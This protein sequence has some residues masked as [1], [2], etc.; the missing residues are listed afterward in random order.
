MFRTLL[1]TLPSMSG[2]VKLNCNLDLDH[3]YNNKIIYAKIGK[4]FLT[5]ADH[6]KSSYVHNVNLLNSRWDYDVSKF[7]SFYSKVFF[8]SQFVFDKRD[9][10]KLN[11]YDTIKQRD[12]DFE[13]GVSRI[14]Y[15]VYGKQLSFFAPIYVDNILDLPNQFEIELKY[16]YN[17]KEIVKKIIVPI[18]PENYT[19]LYD[20]DNQFYNYLYRYIK[21]IDSKI[22]FLNNRK[23]KYYGINLLKGGLSEAE[24]CLI[25]SQLNTRFYPIQKVDSLITSGFQQLKMC[26]KQILPL[27]F[28]FDLNDLLSS[29]EAGKI[30]L[31]KLSIYG[32]YKYTD[33]DRHELKNVTLPVYDFFIDPDKLYID[34]LS[35]DRTNLKLK[36]VKGKN[37]NLL[38]ADAPGLHESQ[39][40]K[41]QFSNRVSPNYTKWR[42]QKSS[43]E[44][45]SVF[46]NQDY[47]V[48]FNSL[49]DKNSDYFSTQ[50]QNYSVK[51]ISGICNNLSINDNIS[52][53]NLVLP[54]YSYS[55]ADI[56]N[57]RDYDSYSNS[58]YDNSDTLIYWENLANGM[59]HHLNVIYPS[60]NYLSYSI[61]DLS[62]SN[63]IQNNINKII[64]ECYF[65]SDNG[66]T[67]SIFD[68][69][70]PRY[71]TFWHTP[72]NDSAFYNGLLYDLSKIECASYSKYLTD[73][74]NRSKYLLISYNNNIIEYLNYQNYD[75]WKKTQKITK[76]GAF[77]LPLP[78][79]N[80][81]NDIYSV[82]NSFSK[83]SAGVSINVGIDNLS[84]TYNPYFDINDLNNNSFSIETNQ[85]FGRVHTTLNDIDFNQES[86][87]NIDYNSYYF[88]F[89]DFNDNFFNSY[90]KELKKYYSNEYV[91]INDVLANRVMSYVKVINDLVKDHNELSYNVSADIDNT[92][93]VSYICVFDLAKLN[94]RLNS[95]EV[96]KEEFMSYVGINSLKFFDEEIYESLY[97]N[98]KE[99]F[100]NTATLYA[101]FV[102]MS[103]DK[104]KNNYL[105]SVK[106]SISS[107]IENAYVFINETNIQNIIYNGTRTISY[108]GV[109]NNLY[110]KN[111][112]DSSEF[113]P[114]NFSNNKNVINSSININKSKMYFKSNLCLKDDLE[115]VIQQIDINLTDK[116]IGNILQSS[117][118]GDN[119]ILMNEECRS[120]IRRIFDWLIK[121]GGE[122]LKWSFDIDDLTPLTI[123]YQRYKQNIDT[124]L[125]DR[126]FKMSSKYLNALKL[127]Y[128]K[129]IYNLISNTSDIKTS[130]DVAGSIITNSIASKEY[131]NFVPK[132][133][134]NKSEIAEN[135][136]AVETKD[137][138]RDFFDEP[139]MCWVDTLNIKESDLSNAPKKFYSMFLSDAHIK[140]YIE[141]MCSSPNGLKVYQKTN[142]NNFKT[143]NVK[144]WLSI[145][146]DQTYEFDGE[147][148]I[149]GPFYNIFIVE[150][151]LVYET[152]SN[153]Y[154]SKYQYTSF[155]EWLKT[156]IIK[157]YGDKYSEIL[158][159]I[160]NDIDLN[161]FYEC[162][163]YK[164]DNNQV[165]KFNFNYIFDKDRYLNVE[166]AESGLCIV[167]KSNFIPLS[168]VQMED[169]YN[170]FDSNGDLRND[171]NYVSSKKNYFI[172][173]LYS[174][175]DFDRNKSFERN[176]IIITDKDCDSKSEWSTIGVLC[177]IYDDSMSNLYHITIRESILNNIK[178][179]KHDGENY[180]K[181]NAD[182]NY[183]NFV[184]LTKEV[185][186]TIKKWLNHSD[187]S[188]D[189]TKIPIYTK[190][191][192]EKVVF[193]PDYDV[194]SKYNEFGLLSKYKLY[195]HYEDGE[196]YGFYL[197]PIKVSSNIISSLYTMD[198]PNS[199]IKTK[200]NKFLSVNNVPL[201]DTDQNTLHISVD[202]A[203]NMCSEVVNLLNYNTNVISSILTNLTL[204]KN[205]ENIK[206]LNNLYARKLNTTLNTTEYDIFEAEKLNHTINLNRY[207]HYVEPAFQKVNAENLNYIYN[208]KFKNTGN[209]VTNKSIYNS[210]GDSPIES[211]SYIDHHINIYGYGSSSESYYDNLNLSYNKTII[212]D[213]LYNNII[214][215]FTPY[216]YHDFNF[217]NY[218]MLSHKLVFPLENK[219][220]YESLSTIC[221]DDTRLNRFIKYC[222]DFKGI[223]DRNLILFLYKCYD[224][225]LE[226]IADGL[227]EYSS[228][229]V[230]TGKF[231][232]TLK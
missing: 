49:F 185:W 200:T 136:F 40:Y 6:D 225:N 91:T 35:V 189:L 226:F 195:T 17:D 172:N 119:T 209:A 179:F 53:S 129:Q 124:Y 148:Y 2:N 90:M 23:I 122:N 210:I 67:E 37:L 221:N 81:K 218:F 100:T 115:N 137:S 4:A 45:E 34:Y 121:N 12:T 176:N 168:G 152:A 38:D 25:A 87:Y 109:L 215:Q 73:I 153:R 55:Y 8:K 83:S 46:D 21:E 169:E 20:T 13:F 10:Q 227:D 56:E 82:Q 95:D 223:T 208:I 222:E 9:C 108:S 93:G 62:Y 188:F 126:I 63:W 110:I 79:V 212:N 211:L 164:Y 132:L 84:N 112:L 159:K 207:L 198:N 163:T 123:D 30:F 15:K 220:D 130:F 202:G 174:D 230:Y 66:F 68:K 36:L 111:D 26:S 105:N 196:N 70:N 59:Y 160:W 5:V 199:G 58:Y 161:K 76:F 33:N 61:N 48:N 88:N 65:V 204:L 166:I 31:N 78:G 135:I 127:E 214:E 103:D 101:P 75:N 29:V 165:S 187:I 92:I 1:R 186:D 32:G 106:Q 151:H 118:T 232:F 224:S 47:L 162:L 228:K 194:E 60:K 173:Y 201:V 39:F 145:K 85:K 141:L 138:E 213:L 42:L 11:K 184:Q 22:V 192:A 180:Y 27:T 171:I 99:Y 114:V 94:A 113:Q 170:I 19:G 229:K 41:Y 44:N 107:K 206:I 89:S 205:T 146:L 181:F 64:D 158:Q 177:P 178:S 139:N 52:V 131:F 193:S 134:I 74:D 182:Y 154:I 69:K 71:N 18:R 217:N 80:I 16:I 86:Y 28:N 142:L 183:S 190:Y 104:I 14:Q 125:I 24:S 216:E 3:I 120:K 140:R 157:K 43:L 102:F 231:I 156:K 150:K 96:K 97:N 219:Y 77:I 149:G 203:L 155:A 143:I 175:Y 117:T 98:C 128:D 51:A 147:T 167:Y 197:V 116:K 72:V 50:L 133:Q 7:Y 144:E 54:I 191:D 57:G